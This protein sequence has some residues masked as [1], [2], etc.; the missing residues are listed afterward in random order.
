MHVGRFLCL[1]LVYWKAFSLTTGNSLPSLMAAA[2]FSSAKKVVIYTQPAIS[3]RLLEQHKFTIESY[4]TKALVHGSQLPNCEDSCFLY[5]LPAE[6][7]VQH[8][9]N[10]SA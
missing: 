4:C 8:C 2:L 5:R 6:Q 9:A 3:T 1:L 10:A 7:A